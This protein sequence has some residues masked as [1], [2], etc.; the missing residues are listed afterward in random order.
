[1][2]S[3]LSLTRPRRDG[4][5]LGQGTVPVRSEG[6]I[7][8]WNFSFPYELSDLDPAS[9]KNLQNATSF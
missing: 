3:I 8:A 9:I 4:R 6:G 7:A 5:Q 1:V 2:N